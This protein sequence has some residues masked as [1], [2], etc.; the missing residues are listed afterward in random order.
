MKELL[1]SGFLIMSMVL[2]AQENNYTKQ[3]ELTNTTEDAWQLIADVSQWKHWDSHV[4]DAQLEGGILDNSKGIIVT[5]NSKIVDFEIVEFKQ[6]E[7]YTLR[8][9]LSSGMVYLKRS[10]Q[11]SEKGTIVKL[12]VWFK[13]LS[14]KNFRKY[15]GNDYELILEEELQSIVQLLK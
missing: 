14:I 10:I 12:K 8:H 5:S 3:I 2:A 1:F 15:M 11:S 13:R 7:S 4:V 9:K 6:G